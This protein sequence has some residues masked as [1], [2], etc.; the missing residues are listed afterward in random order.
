M[1]DHDE[2]LDEDT[3]N[4]L[5]ELAA[6]ADLHQRILDRQGELIL[7][8]REELKGVNRDGNRPRT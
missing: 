6:A 1:D 4:L 2:C 5:A 8:L 3:E 7:R